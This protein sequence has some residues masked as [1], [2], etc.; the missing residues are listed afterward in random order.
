MACQICGVE[1]QWYAHKANCPF[2]C[3]DLVPYQKPY[4]N[5]HGFLQ[6]D[7]R[8][9]WIWQTR[10]DVQRLLQWGETA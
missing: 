8:P 6:C 7:L 2:S 5:E 9:K 10:E 1:T 4:F 3:E